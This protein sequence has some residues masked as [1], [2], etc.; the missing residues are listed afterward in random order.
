VAV[1]SFSENFVGDKYKTLTGFG[2]GI[3]PG[4]RVQL[5][6]P[7][8]NGSLLLGFADWRFCGEGSTQA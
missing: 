6:Y 5:N 1:F 4:A 8:L 7:I 2:A 3:I